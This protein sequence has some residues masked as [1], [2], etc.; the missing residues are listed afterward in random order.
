VISLNISASSNSVRTGDVVTLSSV[1]LDRKGKELKS[2]NPSFSFS[3]VSFDGSNSA[4]G[5]VKE[6]KFVADVAGLYTTK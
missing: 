1:M 6:N 3:G 2:L 4:S 5:L